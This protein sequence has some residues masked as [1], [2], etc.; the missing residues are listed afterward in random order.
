MTGTIARRWGGRS[1]ATWIDVNPPYEMP[2]IP[3]EPLH[4]GWDAS[5][6]TASY[7]SRVS[8]AVYSS[9]ATPPDDPVPRT[10]TRQSAKP[11]A[12]NHSPR[13]T[14]AARRQLSLPYGII[15][16][17]AGNRPSFSP[18][19]SPTPSPGCGVGRQMLADSSTPSRT[20]MRASQSTATSKRGSGAGR[21]IGHGA[22]LRGAP[23]APTTPLAPC[24]DAEHGRSV[25]AP[26]PGGV[27]YENPWITVWHDEV[28]RP[29]GSPGIY[30]VVHFENLAAGVVAFD[31]Q[32]PHRPRRPAPLHPRSIFVGDPGGRGA[33]EETALA[34]IQR[35]LREETGL[36]ADRL[37]RAGPARPVQLRDRRAGGALRGFW[38]PPRRCLAGT[39]RIRSPSAG[40]PSTRRSR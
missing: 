21:R 18:T 5:H 12:A 26:S 27:A 2:H 3:T 40:C 38:P 35:E 36:E 24:D 30:G 32:R 4:H 16:R 33:P 28:T 25:R 34:G 39:D 13:V 20:T 31:D 37:A 22:S 14:S 9:S 10:S 8:S 29:D 6:S 19:A 11:R 23:D 17:I 1:A 7:P 15:S